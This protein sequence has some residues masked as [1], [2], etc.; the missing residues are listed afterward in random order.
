[1]QI[2]FTEMSR[3]RGKNELGTRGNIICMIFMYDV[4]VYVH[5]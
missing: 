4:H 2:P 1:M 3:Y 5:A